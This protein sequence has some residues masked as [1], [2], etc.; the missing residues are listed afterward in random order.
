V[1]LFR[2]TRRRPTTAEAIDGRGAA[3]YPGRWNERGVRATYLTTRISLGVL[4]VIVQAGTTTLD[5]FAFYAVDV[6]DGLLT[7][8]DRSRLPDS[9]RTLNGRVE[10]RAFA[11]AW[12]RAGT[13]C[14]LIVPSAVIPEAYDQGEFNVV[15]DPAHPDFQRI[16]IDEPATLMIDARLSALRA[17]P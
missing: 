2:I 1:R 13:S 7:P 6:P 3:R 10:C 15:I 5:G 17:R 11:D 8:L 14:G 16:R 9:W 4:E 12:R